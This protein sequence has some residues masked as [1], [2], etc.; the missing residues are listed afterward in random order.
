MT[1]A[2][3]TKHD[4]KWCARALDL[5]HENNIDDYVTFNIEHHG[6]DV[7]EDFLFAQHLKT[8]PQIWENGNYIGGYSDLVYHLSSKKGV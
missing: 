3:L 5:F 2:I 6:N 7:L 1:Y 8:V 4:C